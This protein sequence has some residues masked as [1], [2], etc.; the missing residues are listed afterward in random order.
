MPEHTDHFLEFLEHIHKIV[1]K[2]ASKLDLDEPII[3]HCSAGI[4]RTGTFVI[5][6]S[7]LC[8][9]EKQ[10]DSND[11]TTLEQLVIFIRKYRMGLIQTPQQLRFCWKAIVDWINTNLFL[12]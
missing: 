11:I 12:K 9:L 7:V 10:N 6:D 2:S 8:M 4:G 1:P 5:V 3:C